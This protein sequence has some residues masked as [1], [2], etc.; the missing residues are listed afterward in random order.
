MLSDG[1]LTLFLVTFGLGAVGW[2]LWVLARRDL[3]EA[4]LEAQEAHARARLAEGEA[5]A[6]RTRT[7]AIEDA[8]AV[9]EAQAR[10]A[11]VELA[12]LRLDLAK[13]TADRDALTDQLEKL[14]ASKS[15]E[16]LRSTTGRLRLYGKGSG[17]RNR[18]DG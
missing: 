18:D 11:H 2:M 12:A 16:M 5:S 4:R 3:R 15:E 6:I 9:A 13:S 1:G 8:R 10:I 7:E 14:G 17:V